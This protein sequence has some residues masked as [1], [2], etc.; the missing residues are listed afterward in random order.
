MIEIRRDSW[1][2]VLVSLGPPFRMEAFQF[3]P[4]AQEGGGHNLDIDQSLSWTGVFKRFGLFWFVKVMRRI[5]AGETI[6]EKE[7]I[8]LRDAQP[9]WSPPKSWRRSA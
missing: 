3:R 4:R 5:K 8:A 2:G 7:L 9:P 1:V 6:T